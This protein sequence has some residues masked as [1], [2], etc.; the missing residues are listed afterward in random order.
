[1]GGYDSDDS[2]RSQ[3]RLTKSSSGSAYH[4]ASLDRYLLDRRDFGGDRTPSWRPSEGRLESIISACDGER[5]IGRCSYVRNVGK[6]EEAEDDLAPKYSS[7]FG[8]LSAARSSM[9]QRRK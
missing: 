6:R 2:Y 9:A 3:H 1:M 5:S 8:I 7:T 4:S